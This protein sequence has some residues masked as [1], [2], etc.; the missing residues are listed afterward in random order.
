LTRTVKNYL[1]LG[2]IAGTLILIDQIT[3]WFVRQ[4]IP[5]NTM[6]APWDWM[7]PYARLFHTENSGVAF[8]MFKGANTIFAILAVIVSIAIIYYYPRIP[9]ED[10]T[11]RIALSMQLAGALGNLIDRVFIGYVTDFIS[12]GTFAIWNIADASITMGVVVLVI[13]VWLQDRKKA[14]PVVAVA[15]E[16]QAEMNDTAGSSSGEDKS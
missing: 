9:Y 11:L 7:Y 1:L 10:W 16:N 13:G 15:E 6:W 2:G 8:G 14:V 3:K 5:V 4:L 12:V